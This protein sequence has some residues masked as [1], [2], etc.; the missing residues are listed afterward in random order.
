MNAIVKLIIGIL[1]TA[2]GIAWYAYPD[3]VRAL[4]FAVD[5]ISS[6]KIIIAGIVG[7]ILIVFGLLLVWIEAEEIR[8][9]FGEIR[10]SKKKSKK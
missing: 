2:A 10:G 4:G 9:G 5:P 3:G 6:L 1:I 7:L 8:E